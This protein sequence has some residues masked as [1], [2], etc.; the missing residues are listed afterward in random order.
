MPRIPT[1]RRVATI[2]GPEGMAMPRATA[3]AF[4]GLEGR[5]MEVGGK[6]ASNVFLQ[7]GKEKSTKEAQIYAN[8]IVSEQRAHFAERSVILRRTTDGDIAP[9]LDVEMKDAV[10][11][12]QANAPNKAALEKVTMGLR[13]MFGTMRAREIGADSQYQDAR[14]LQS[15]DTAHES[16]KSA[17]YNS[18]SLLFSTVE[19]TKKRIDSLAIDPNTKREK[20]AEAVFALGEAAYRGSIESS[21]KSAQ[22]VL[23]ELQDPSKSDDIAKVLKQSDKDK[24]IRYA[25]QTI[26]THQAERT[27]LAT[28]RRLEHTDNQRDIKED[29]MVKF[30]DPKQTVTMETVRKYQLDN[31]AT[32]D[33]ST[34]SFFHDLLRVAASGDPAPP[35]SD[36]ASRYV[37]HSERVDELSVNPDKHAS[38]I[39][40]EEDAIDASMKSRHI[41]IAQGQQLKKRLRAPF[42][43][44]KKTLL[45]TVKQAL[46]KANPMYGITDHKGSSLFAQA[47]IMIDELLAEG[48]GNKTPLDEFYDPKSKHYLNDKVITKYK[49]TPIE[50]I[51]DFQEELGI[52]NKAKPMESETE[53]D[54]I[55]RVRALFKEKF[56]WSPF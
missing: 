56:G 45:A 14:L 18:P 16:D 22:N 1:Y 42:D 39:Y 41:T 19:A 12:A 33:G 51:K 53:D 44:R 4:G 28:Q 34:I 2:P 47:E 54:T 26:R 55:K 31:G 30:A 11:T 3:A 49:R 43:A 25:D 24:L 21:E 52:G 13:T 17:V 40:S 29:L 38:E 27:R 7:I 23:K 10:A 6:E 9:V 32:P 35:A 50:I 8:K 20:I 37:S 15:N 48:E 5:A 36:R 46:V